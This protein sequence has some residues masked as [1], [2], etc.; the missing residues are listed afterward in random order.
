ML[1]RIPEDYKTKRS[2]QLINSL[3]GED[4]PFK[5]K[6][7]I[8]GNQEM[9]DYMYNKFQ[10]FHNPTEDRETITT[11]KGFNFHEGKEEEDTVMIMEQ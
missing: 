11:V 2:S 6:I 10:Q 5:K 8:I 3:R 7:Q 9:T 4:I 1:G